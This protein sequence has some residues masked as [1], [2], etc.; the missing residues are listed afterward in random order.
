ML[1]FKY[2]PLMLFCT[3]SGIRYEVP[4]C[5]VYNFIPLVL[6]TSWTEAQSTEIVNVWSNSFCVELKALSVYFN[7]SLQH[8]VKYYLSLKTLHINLNSC[9][10]VSVIVI[11]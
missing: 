2:I 6:G 7:F 10:F 4:S 11:S 8:I 5:V 1:P 9:W 3:Y